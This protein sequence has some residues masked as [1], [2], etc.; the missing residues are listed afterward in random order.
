[1]GVVAAV[2]GPDVDR[3][4]AGLLRPHGACQSS[5]PDLADPRATGLAQGLWRR[6]LARLQLGD[7][8]GLD[9][10][11]LALSLSILVYADNTYRENIAVANDR[12]PSST[13]RP[14]RLQI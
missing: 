14:E 4:P 8:A 11:L 2:F 12:P 10:G 6:G 3:Y 13:H 1:M 7:V 9:E 5:A